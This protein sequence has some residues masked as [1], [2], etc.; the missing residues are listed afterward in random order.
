MIK[1]SR[2]NEDGNLNPSG[3]SGNTRN[4][5]R[6]PASGQHGTVKDP[7]QQISV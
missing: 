4:Y 5:V 6:N 1:V 3:K 2:K 7:A